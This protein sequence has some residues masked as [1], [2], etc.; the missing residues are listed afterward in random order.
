MSACPTDDLSPWQGADAF[1]WRAPATSAGGLGF[2]KGLL[3]QYNSAMR[4]S[5]H[6]CVSR[7]S[8]STLPL[9][10]FL[11]FL[12]SKSPFLPLLLISFPIPLR[13]V[14]M[15]IFTFCFFTTSFFHRSFLCSVLLLPIR[16]APLSPSPCYSFISSLILSLRLIARSLPSS[17]PPVFILLLPSH[18]CPHFFC[19]NASFLPY[20][21]PSPLPPCDPCLIL[22]SCA[23]SVF[24]ST[25]IRPSSSP[26]H[27]LLRHVLRLLS[28]SSHLPLRLPLAQTATSPI[29]RFLLLPTYP[30]F[31]HFP[32]TSALPHS[33]HGSFAPPHFLPSS[34]LPLTPSPLHLRACLPL[35]PSFAST[36]R[37]LPPP[38]PPLPLLPLLPPLLPLTSQRLSL[39]LPHLPLLFHL[40]LPPSLSSTSPSS[41]PPPP[42][43]PAPSYPPPP[44]HLTAL[45]L[46]LLPPPPL[47]PLPSHLPFPL[48][49]LPPS[50]SPLLPPLTSQ[51]PLFS[52][53]LTSLIRLCQASP[54]QL[55]SQR[56]PI[57]PCALDTLLSSLL[58]MLRA[59]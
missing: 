46:S 56:L 11:F 8:P 49:P 32:R 1:A 50:T 27:L 9:S 22:A 59:R 28:C 25:P 13:S 33:P 5:V 12:L 39:L 17:L 43:P 31:M 42:L 55:P 2:C 51:P 3:T 54:R 15:V 35:L 29:P 14:Q 19:S 20:S 58:D 34:A 48:L 47:P 52:L 57:G 6:S 37:P 44:P 30:L 24:R 10:S 41:P 38:L 40:P 21:S 4:D 36:C 16:A 26:I 53:T 23:A 7:V 45:F 18:T